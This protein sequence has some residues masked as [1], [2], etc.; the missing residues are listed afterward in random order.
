MALTG[1]LKRVRAVILADMVGQSGL[2][3]L[4]DSDSPKWL[5]DTVWDTAAR[6]RYQSVFVSQATSTEDDNLPFLERHVPVIDL[7]DLDDYIRLGYWHTSQ[8]TLDKISPRSLAI[9]GHVILESVNALQ[10]KFH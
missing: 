2:H 10:N 6:L 4:R 5:T 1:E 3:I 9:V 7:I 8:D